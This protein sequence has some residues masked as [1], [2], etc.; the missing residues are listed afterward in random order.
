[1]EVVS[2]DSL[3]KWLKERMR[4]TVGPQHA[5]AKKFL[6]KINEEKVW[7]DLADRDF[8]D[9]VISAVRYALGRQTY[10][11]GNT[12]DFV[13]QLLPVLHPITLAILG[14]DIANAWSY[15]NE[16]IDKPYWMALLDDIEAEIKKRKVDG[17][18]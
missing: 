18:A 17:N 12:C 2:K 8:G 14:R 5:E 15:G 16:K 3:K 7:F 4:D 1:M 6:D 10:I 9:M 11:V 13:R